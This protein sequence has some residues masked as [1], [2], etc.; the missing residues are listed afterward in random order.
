MLEKT[1]NHSLERNP[2]AAARGFGQIFGIHPAMAFLTLIV[3]MML[4]GG[5][6]GTLGASLPISFAGGIVLAFITFR[7]QKKWYGDDTESAFIKA[8]I[9]G[10]LTAL[11]TA[12]PSV[13]YVPAGVVGLVH[14]LRRK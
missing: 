6:V 9:L 12:L 3:D 10:F 1:S 4:F 5:E 13:I 8:L 11:P 2:H 14:N 7:A